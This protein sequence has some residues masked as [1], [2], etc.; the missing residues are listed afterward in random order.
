MD[1]LRHRPSQAPA[2]QTLLYFAPRPNSYYLALHLLTSAFYLHLSL[3]SRPQPQ[4]I[5]K[6]SIQDFPQ[7]E[8]PSLLPLLPVHLSLALP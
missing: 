1:F 7:L 2:L 8:L 6:S 3:E 5:L 4:L